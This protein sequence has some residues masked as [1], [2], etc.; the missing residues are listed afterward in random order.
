MNPCLVIGRLVWRLFPEAAPLTVENFRQL[1]KGGHYNNSHL[2][3]AQKDFCLQGGLWNLRGSPFPPIKLEYKYV[4][5]HHIMY[6]I[7][8]LHLPS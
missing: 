5:H 4:S 1:V 8:F 3:R 2:Y 6:C 7:L